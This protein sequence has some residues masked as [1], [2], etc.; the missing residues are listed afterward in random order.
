MT[1]VADYDKLMKRR[2]AGLFGGPLQA[3]VE[4]KAAKILKKA[5]IRPRVGPGRGGAWKWSVDRAYKLEK[6]RRP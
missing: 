3:T 2:R 5:G 4:H 1:Y 6:A